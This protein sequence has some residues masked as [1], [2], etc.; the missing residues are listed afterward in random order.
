MN[1]SMQAELQQYFP[2][3][4]QY[5]EQISKTEQFFKLKKISNKK[6]NSIFWNH[7]LSLI[8]RVITKNQN[9]YPVTEMAE[10]SE[11]AKLLTKEYLD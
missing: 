4:N 2:D 7:L 9:D 11:A 10:I 6:L 8:Q 1:K 5:Q 3:L